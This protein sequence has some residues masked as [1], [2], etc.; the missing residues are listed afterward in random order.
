MSDAPSNNKIT[1]LY[2]NQSRSFQPLRESFI[3]ENKEGLS[4]LPTL[5]GKE[6]RYNISLIKSVINDNYSLYG[7]S[8]TLWSSDST[9]SP[10]HNFFTFN[11]NQIYQ[12]LLSISIPYRLFGIVDCD[13]LYFKGELNPEREVNELV[14]RWREQ[15]VIDIAENTT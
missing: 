15:I 14:D 1:F 3:K 5:K 12:I 13:I 7:V 8:S 11:Q 10:M 6:F 2:I 9:I 4:L